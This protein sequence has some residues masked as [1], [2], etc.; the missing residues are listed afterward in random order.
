MNYNC[1]QFWLERKGMDPLWIVDHCRRV[2]DR[3]KNVGLSPLFLHAEYKGMTSLMC[4]ARAMT[5]FLEFP[6]NGLP[7]VNSVVEQEI[8]FADEAFKLLRQAPYICHILQANSKRY[9]NIAYIS[10]K[11]LSDAG[12]KNLNR[13]QG[14][15]SGKGVF[16]ISQK[17]MGSDDC[18]LLPTQGGRW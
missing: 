6:W 16:L 2:L 7:A 14:V 9:A 4:V 11:L 13:F 1:I 12:E 17:T 10:I 18:R 15:G 3:T 5:L 8:I